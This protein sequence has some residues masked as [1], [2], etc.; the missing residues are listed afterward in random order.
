MSKILS[1]I[2]RSLKTR[3]L[4]HCFSSVQFSN[5]LRT[6]S[7]TISFVVPTVSIFLCNF[8][9]PPKI[10][11]FHKSSFPNLIHFTLFFLSDHSLLLHYFSFYVRFC[12][13]CRD[14]TSKNLIGLRIMGFS[15][16]FSA[17]FLP[18]SSLNDNSFAEWLS[19]ITFLSNPQ[20]NSRL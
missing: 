3:C 17:D 1:P 6:L 19:C 9:F 2:F 15:S 4:C 18:S 8:L 5:H 14:C 11:Y 20:I 16:C 13:S 7:Q 12:W 10:C